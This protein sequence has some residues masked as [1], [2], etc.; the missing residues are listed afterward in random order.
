MTMGEQELIDTLH[1]HN[2]LCRFMQSF[3]DKDW[4]QM[5]ACL[6]DTVF[7]DYSSFRNVPPAA[8]PAERYVAQR[9]AALSALDL[10][11]NFTNLRVEVQG[12][13]ASARCNYIIHRFHP[14]FTGAADEFF[15]SYGHYEYTLRR[16]VNAWKIDRIAQ[17]LLKNHG[18]PELHGATRSVDRSRPG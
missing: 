9:R 3:D 15:H 4:Q 12:D 8:I 7:C 10:Q 17:Y 11:H 13:R 14:N 2:L 1:I 6:H 18:N 16:I 5:R